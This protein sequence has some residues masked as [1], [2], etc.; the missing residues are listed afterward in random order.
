MT[1]TTVPSSWDLTGRVAVVTGAARGIGNATAT[2]LRARGAQLIVTDRRDTVEQLARHDP[3]HVAAL[4]GDVADEELAR[5]T[6]RLA[7][8]R[9]GR[10]DI[11]VN[12]ATRR[13]SSPARS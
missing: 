8:D 9:F 1:S 13:A 10:L 7:I 6:M 11:L 12:N 3:D 2:L 5:A 4:V